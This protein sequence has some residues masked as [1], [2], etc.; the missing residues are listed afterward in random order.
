MAGGRRA[1]F[2]TAA[3]GRYE[4]ALS[5]S[6]ASLEFIRRLRVVH[7]ALSNL[8]G[9]VVPSFRALSG[10]LTFKV[11]RHKFNQDSLSYH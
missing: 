10:C 7:R 4:A 3:V 11:R 8:P 5:L 2:L 1:S 6:S 9:P